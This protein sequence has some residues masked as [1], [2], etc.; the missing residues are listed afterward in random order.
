MAQ[1][2]QCF[3]VHFD[4]VLICINCK[5]W[6]RYGGSGT[7]P[8][9]EEVYIVNPISLHP[10]LQI[11][12]SFANILHIHFTC[13][14]LTHLLYLYMYSSTYTPIILGVANPDR[15]YNQLYNNYNIFIIWLVY[16]SK[17]IINYIII[18]WLIWFNQT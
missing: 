13:H 14:S 6:E 9:V 8:K 18:L 16:N 15:V 10:L 5:R 11:I 4:V 17:K 3:W 12:L 2:F 7:F 1:K